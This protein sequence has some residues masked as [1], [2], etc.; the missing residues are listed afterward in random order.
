MKNVKKNSTKNDKRV[1]T[2]LNSHKK[3]KYI[4]N[5]NKKKIQKKIRFSKKK[6][7]IIFPS[8]S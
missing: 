4:K 3:K 2:P 7:T 6:K 1:I 5:S 8:F